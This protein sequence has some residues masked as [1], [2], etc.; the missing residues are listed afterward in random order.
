MPAAGA[1]HSR[2]CTQTKVSGAT[3][4]STKMFYTQ[5]APQSASKISSYESLLINVTCFLKN[6]VQFCRKKP[7]KTGLQT[8]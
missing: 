4:K 6:I 1:E 3:K 8:H 5:K 7:L 2:S